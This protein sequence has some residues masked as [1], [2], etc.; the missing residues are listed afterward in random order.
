MAFSYL[1][2][3]YCGLCPILIIIYI[4]TFCSSRITCPDNLSYID[5]FLNINNLYYLLGQL[6]VMYKK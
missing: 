1:P 5:S 2:H 3:G 6:P 4:A